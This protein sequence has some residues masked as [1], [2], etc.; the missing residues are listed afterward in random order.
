MSVD[1][2]RAHVLMAQEFL[3]GAAIIA[4]FRHKLHCQVLAVDTLG[5]VVARLR[6]GGQQ[7]TRRI[8]G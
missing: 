2:G 7:R 5:R 4:G 6:I 3:H 8:C 1:H